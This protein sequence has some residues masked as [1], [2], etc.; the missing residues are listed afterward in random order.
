MCYH[1]P[2]AAI[3]AAVGGVHTKQNGPR[4]LATNTGSAVTGHDVP[5]NISRTAVLGR[6]GGRR[7]PHSHVLVKGKRAFQHVLEIGRIA[8]IKRQKTLQKQSSVFKHGA[9]RHHP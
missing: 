9:E 7:A 4:G 8:R 3:G 5:A 6:L 1:H 2:D